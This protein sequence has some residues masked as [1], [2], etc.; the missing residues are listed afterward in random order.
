[1]SYKKPIVIIL[2]WW[3]WKPDSN[4]FMNTKISLENMWY[5][6]VVPQLPNTN[7]PNLEEQLS[8]LYQFVDK[9]NKDSIII[10]HSLWGQLALFFVSTLNK[11]IKSVI[12]V[13]PTYSW[14]ADDMWITSREK[15]NY[16]EKAFIK[17]TS[18]E[19]NFKKVSENTDF[20][21]L[22]ISK[23]DPYIAFDKVKKYYK[24]LPYLITYEYSDKKH[25]NWTF[26]IFELPEVLED[27]IDLKKT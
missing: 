20:Q 21:V 12:I 27:I 3:E 6:V 11:K 17:Y 9:L 23:N 19:I 10:W 2:H 4:W 16:N 8:F 25:F 22:H 1:M 7:T 14:V 13:S 5:D 24:K 18:T 26:W 15:L